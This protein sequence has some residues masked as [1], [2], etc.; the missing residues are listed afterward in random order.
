MNATIFIANNLLTCS[1]CRRCRNVKPDN[2][3]FALV[4]GTLNIYSDSITAE[5]QHKV[6]KHLFTLKI[7]AL[8]VE[9][10]FLL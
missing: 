1:I 6:N 3:K 5:L 2:P 8:E 9:I 7:E 10:Y 4:P